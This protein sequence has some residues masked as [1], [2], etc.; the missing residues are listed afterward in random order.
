MSTNI[1]QAQTDDTLI[2]I[3]EYPLW[4]Q[5]IPL[6]GNGLVTQGY[7][8]MPDEW[9][10][11]RL[12]ASLKGKSFIDI[13]SN[14]GFFSFEAEKRGARRVVAVDLYKSMDFLSMTSGWNIKGISLVKAYTKSE[15]DIRPGSIYNL[16][17]LNETFDIAF[18][19]N[20][21]TWVR[22]IPR[23]M[24]QLSKISREKI[25]ILD[26]FDTE[27]T[28]HTVG[29]NYDINNLSVKAMCEYLTQAGWSKITIHKFNEARRN[30]W[31][32]EYFPRVVSKGTIKVYKHPYSDEVCDQ[33]NIDSPRNVLST[34]N[35]KSYIK[36]LGWV[37][38]EDI[39]SVS[40]YNHSFLKSLMKKIIG[41]RLIDAYRNFK[42]K[43]VSKAVMIIAEK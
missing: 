42:D 23:A 32:F 30:R 15:V 37:N 2:S 19:N 33:A 20:V 40:T 35:G 29:L 21:L 3:L 26:L 18:C 36:H 25:I 38:K 10:E 13:G 24:D 34:L 1:Q 39:I 41:K 27:A 28:Y 14:D 12:P 8:I 22:D 7:L 31:D 43:N 9:K 16:D 4:R 6:N 17:E 5:R 11:C